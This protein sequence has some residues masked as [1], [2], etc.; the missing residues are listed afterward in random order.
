MLQGLWKISWLSKLYIFQRICRI[1]IWQVTLLQSPTPL[2]PQTSFYRCLRSKALVVGYGQATSALRL[3]GKLF[4]SSA[5][6]PWAAERSL[7]S[8]RNLSTSMANL[9]TS[10]ANQETEA[11]QYEAKLQSRPQGEAETSPFYFP[12]Q[13]KFIFYKFQGVLLA[14]RIFSKLLGMWWRTSLPRLGGLCPDIRL[15]NRSQGQLLRLASC[16]GATGEGFGCLMLFDCSVST[17][18]YFFKR[19]LESTNWQVK[20]HEKETWNLGISHDTE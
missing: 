1:A 3:Q 9:L 10:P 19:L 8:T 13:L 17:A 7:A 11:W 16:H 14:M 18:F 4:Q 15:Q 20:N 2:H 5:L 12:S 6:P